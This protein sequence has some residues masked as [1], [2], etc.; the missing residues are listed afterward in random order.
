VLHPITVERTI[1]DWPEPS[2]MKELVEAGQA[3]IGRPQT[4]TR[5]INKLIDA[6]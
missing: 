1:G 2:S 5:S 3:T 6:A 4:C